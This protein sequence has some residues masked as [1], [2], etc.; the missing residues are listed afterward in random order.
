MRIEDVLLGEE[1]GDLV[2]STTGA[3]PGYEGLA[4]L[5]NDGDQM[6]LMNPTDDELAILRSI[7]VNPYYRPSKKFF[8]EAL[9]DYRKTRLMR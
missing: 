4:D 3:Q 1:L 5:L 9:L 2:G 8:I 7:R 6:L